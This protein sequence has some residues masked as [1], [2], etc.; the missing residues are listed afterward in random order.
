MC[1]E[2][3][4]CGVEK[5]RPGYKFCEQTTGSQVGTCQSESNPDY[6][7]GA[8]S[9]A[10]C[11]VENASITSCDASQACAVAVCEENFGDCDADQRNG[12][13]TDLRT[14]VSNCSLCGRA[15]E[16]KAHAV[17]GCESSA[18]VIKACE[19]AWLNCNTYIGDGCEW[20]AGANGPCPT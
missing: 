12:C 3:G 1:T 5:C 14:D 17:V 7:C 10:P 18:C 20:D 13:E 11:Q 8:E 6:G 2:S 16:E 9:C 4:E 15:C 19:G